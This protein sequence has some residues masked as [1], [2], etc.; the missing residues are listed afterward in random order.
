MWAKSRPLRLAGA[1][2]AVLAFVIA[3]QDVLRPMANTTL[4]FQFTLFSAI[5]IVG[6]VMMLVETRP[7]YAALDFALSVLATCGLF[8]LLNAAFL[9]AATVIVYAGAIIVT[10]LF[11]IMLAQQSG[12]A[13]Y[14]AHPYRPVL[15]SVAG[16]LLLAGLLTTLSRSYPP[17]ESLG[18]RP[19][20]RLISP[21][22]AAGHTSR[23]A[24]PGASSP[25]VRDLGRTL[26]GDYVWA[27]EL[28]GAVLLAATVGAVAIATQRKGIRT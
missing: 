9:A 28:A 8:L 24:Q 14:D 12:L 26:F 16:A 1:M 25:G 18:G 23:L 4:A 17:G 7:V 5:A 3:A 11:V 27:V 6:A 22:A 21:E 10:F 19:L 13:A 15:G 20:V 2:V